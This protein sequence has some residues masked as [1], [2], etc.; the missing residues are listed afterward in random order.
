MTMPETTVNKDRQFAAKPY[1]VRFAREFFTVDAITGEAKFP[2][3]P[4]HRKL[5]QSVF[6]PDAP[7]IF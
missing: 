2:A 5:R 1:N 6:S 3:E 7:H 4:A